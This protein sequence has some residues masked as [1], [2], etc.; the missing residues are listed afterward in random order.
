MDRVLLPVGVLLCWIVL[1]FSSRS[2]SSPPGV[3]QDG[4]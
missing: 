2:V 4:Q 1:A 3:V